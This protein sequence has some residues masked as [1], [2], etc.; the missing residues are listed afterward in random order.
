MRLMI[1][2]QIG[3]ELHDKETRGAS[4][5][6]QE[7]A[8]LDAWYRQKDAAESQSNSRNPDSGT[9]EVLRG[10]LSQ[11]L[12]QVKSMAQGIQELA[13]ANDALLQ[14]TVA[15]RQRLTERAAPQAA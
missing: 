14:E 13:R 12:D 7:R 15:L 5:S 1:A 3:Q 4:L 10:Q 11:A 8:Q 6:S 2:D 9:V